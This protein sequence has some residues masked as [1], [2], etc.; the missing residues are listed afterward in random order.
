[1]GEG[2]LFL[3]VGEDE[4]VIALEQKN[5][6]GTPSSLLNGLTTHLN[7]MTSRNDY[8]LSFHSLNNEGEFWEA[9]ESH[10]SKDGKITSITFDMV[11]PNPPDAENPTKDGLEKL[12]AK[13]NAERVK[14]TISNPTGLK[15][16]ND[17]VKNRESY[18]Q[19]GGGDITVKDGKKTI[20]N[21]KKKQRQL[22][23]DEDL[24][25]DGNEKME[26]FAKLAR[27]LRR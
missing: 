9:V 21:S 27:L 19:T 12:K 22:H 17:E 16:D 3:N 7:D 1:M 13:T 2:S 4:Q 23:I 11:V 8:I 24:Y 18:I 5:G 15:L 6:V 25:P 14:E 10:H 26:L 20:Y